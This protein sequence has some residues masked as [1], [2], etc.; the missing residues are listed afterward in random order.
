MALG[1]T[2]QHLHFTSLDG[3]NLGDG[4]LV[5]TANRF[6]DEARPFDIDQLTLHIDA[7]VATLYANVGI[8]RRMEVGFAAPMVALRLNGSRVNTY[9]GRAFTQARASATAIGLADMV[10]RTKYTLFDEEGAGVAAALDVRLP[11]GHK[12]DLLGAGTT[13]I[14]VSAIGS[15]ENGRVS[16]HANAGMSFGGLARELSYGAAVALAATPHVTMTG[17]LL[18]RWLDSFGHIVQAAALN[19]RLIGVETIRLT[20]DAST[21]HS[22]TPVLGVKW[23]VTDT[24]VLAANVSFPLTTG[25]L[26]SKF[27][28]FVGMDYALGR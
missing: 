25:G 5:T 18:G 10:V 23:N 17:E 7:D 26:Q 15:L 2:L 8:T 19:P 13:S 27:T 28:P 24:W 20:P 16:S 14:K 22:L 1:L 21:M 9:R 6:V 11:T 4:T 12:E 3:S